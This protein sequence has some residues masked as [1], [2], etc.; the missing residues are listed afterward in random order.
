MPEACE[1]DA[2][3]EPAVNSQPVGL[4]D[5]PL[6]DG[7]SIPQLGFGVWQVPDGEVAGA[8]RMASEA[9][10]RLIDTAEGYGNERGVGEALST[11]SAATTPLRVTTKLDANTF[12]YDAIRR[13]FD[14]SLARLGRERVDLYLIHWPRPSER[15]FRETWRT[16]RSIRDDGLAASIGVCN[17]EETHLRDIVEDSGEVPAVNQ[18]ELHPWLPQTALRAIHAELGIVTQAW[19]PLA[20]GALLSDPALVALGDRLGATPAQIVLRWHV[21]SGHAV[22]P[23]SV[24]PARIRANLALNSFLLDEDAHRVLASLESG[25]R[26]GPH[27]DAF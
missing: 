15:R 16:L 1:R 9:G 3:A 23:K 14:A 13:A 22:L 5:L 19:S 25:E 27:P 4:R 7:R 21:E 24:T 8:V 6:H 10:Y 17:F 18:I 2:A 20:S 12:G 11:L 26:T